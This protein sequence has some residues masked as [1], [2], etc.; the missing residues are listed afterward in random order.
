MKKRVISAILILCMAI[1]M[2]PISAMAAAKF[3]IKADE[4]Y[5]TTD[6]GVII[7]ISNV[8]SDAEEVTLFING[9][10][11]DTVAAKKS[12]FPTIKNLDEGAYLMQAVSYDEDGEE[13]ERS[14]CLTVLVYDE[15]YYDDDYFDDCEDVIFIT[16]PVA[17]CDVALDEKVTISSLIYVPEFETA[18]YALNYIRSGKKSSDEFESI[19]IKD[20]GIQ[21]ISYTFEADDVEYFD[22]AE[23]FFVVTCDNFDYTGGSCELTVTE[24]LDITATISSTAMTVAPKKSVKLTVDAEDTEN[25]KAKLS[26]QWMTGKTS[27]TTNLSSIK[28]ETDATY[29]FT[30]PEKEGVYYYFCKVTSNKSDDVV[31]VSCTLT[32]KDNAAS[33]DNFK[34]VNTFTSGMFSDVKTTDWFNTYVEKAYTLNLMTGTSKTTFTPAGNFKISEAV[35]VAARIFSTYTNDGHE[36]KTTAPWYQTYVD[37]AVDNGII[38]SNDFANYNVACTRAQMAYIL[39][40]ALPTSEFKALKTVSTLPDVTTSTAYYSSIFA[41]YEAG[42]LT[43]SDKAGTFHPTNNIKRS[44]VA[45]IV[46]RIALP[47]TRSSAKLG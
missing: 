8:D 4:D 9:E 47:S 39:Y 32:V 12:K 5:Y 33:M 41:L 15:E 11:E 28:G 40:N 30:A 14:N 7:S 35:A 10:E 20:S 24:K 46:C 34:A 22:G 23:L 3:T 13:L 16:E 26:Y 2:L 17:E 25:K 27:K 6:D 36:F 18:S 38:R 21:V 29:S 42:I 43:G 45:A 31:Y 1:S 37:Y 44:E 19:K